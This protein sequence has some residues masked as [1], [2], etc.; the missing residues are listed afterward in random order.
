MLIAEILRLYSL[1]TCLYVSNVSILGI[2]GQF[3]DNVVLFCVQFHFFEYRLLCKC[4]SGRNNQMAGR[5]EKDKTSTGKEIVGK[6]NFLVFN[7]FRKIRK[8]GTLISPLFILSKIL[9]NCYLPDSGSVVYCP[10]AGVKDY[11]GSLYFSA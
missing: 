4:C 5:R 10:P 6:I 8:K 9:R 11:T 3:E 7:I 2:Y 1:T